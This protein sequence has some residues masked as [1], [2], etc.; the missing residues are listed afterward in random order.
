[1]SVLFII[2]D[3]LLPISL[4]ILLGIVAGRSGMMKSE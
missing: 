1:M 4:V 2:I 3:A